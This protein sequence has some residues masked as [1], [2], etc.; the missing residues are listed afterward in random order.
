M[1]KLLCKRGYVFHACN[2]ILA[3]LQ[4]DFECFALLCGKVDFDVHCHD[5]LDRKVL[6]IIFAW[7]LSAGLSCDD[8]LTGYIWGC[9]LMEDCT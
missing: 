9:H 6:V 7:W 8:R 5:V 1:D 4:N 2:P 3:V